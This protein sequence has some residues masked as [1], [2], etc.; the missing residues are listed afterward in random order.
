[1]FTYAAL[2]GLEDNWG[3]RVAGSL[4]SYNRLA[5]DSNGGKSACLTSYDGGG[6]GDLISISKASQWDMQ[7]IVR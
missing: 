4:K 7:I 3:L 1:M 5:S 2:G 6:R